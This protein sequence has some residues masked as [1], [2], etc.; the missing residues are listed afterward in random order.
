V[1]QIS[2]ALAAIA[3]LSKKKWVEYAMFAAGTIGLAV[4]ALAALH[5]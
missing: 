4:G 2:I 5:I 1:L 3:L